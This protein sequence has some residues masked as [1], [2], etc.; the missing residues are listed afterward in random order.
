MKFKSLKARI[1]VVFISIILTIQIIGAVAIRFNIEKN[2]RASVNEQLVIGEK[3]FLS[4]LNQ[5]VEHLSQGARILA[6]D[7]GFR[8]AIGSSDSE[9][10]LSALQNQQERLGADLSIFFTSENDDLMISG[11]LSSEEIKKTIVKLIT[12]SKAN[13]DTKTFAIFQEQPYQLVAVPIKAPITIGWV[14]MGFKINDKLVK[15]LNQLS[16]LEV[17]FVSK[18]N[19]K[20]WSSTA[21]SLSLSEFSKLLTQVPAQLASHK[22][23]LETKLNDTVYGTRFV[24]IFN[25][26]NQQLYA[27]L[28]R[29][30]NEATSAYQSLQIS[31]MVLTIIGLLIIVSTILYL[32]KVITQPITDLVENAKKLEEGNYDIAITADSEDELGH[33]GRTF[34]RMTEAIAEREKSI[35]KLAYYDEL[36]SLPNRTSFLIALGKSLQTFAD[37]KQTLTVLVLNLDR[38]KQINNIL[39]YDAG[40]EILRILALRIK[41]S[42]KNTTDIIA[43]I[44][45]DQFAIMLLNTSIDAAED[46]ST[47]LLKFLET[48]IQIKNQTVDLSASVGLANYP[49]HANN[50]TE[51]ISRA[52]MAMHVAKSKNVG[53]VI[54]DKSFDLNSTANLSLESELRLAIAENQLELYVQPKIDIKTAKV[55]SL[56]ALIRWKHPIKGYIFPD[57]FI[58]FAEQTGFIHHI[59]LWVMNEAASLIAMWRDQAIQ[60]PIAINIS[61]RDLIDQNLTAQVLEIF[62][63][64]QIN[65]NS[66]EISFEITESSIMDDPVRALTTLDKLAS[67]QI[68]LSIDDFGTGYS[69]L[70]YLK[71]LPVSELKIDKS[72]VLKLEEDEDDRKIVQST[73]DLG[74]NLGLKVVAEGVENESVWHLL[75]QMGCDFGQGYYM[76]KPMHNN[77]F[78]KWLADWQTSEVYQSLIKEN[79]NKIVKP[80]VKDEVIKNRRSNNSPMRSQFQTIK[81]SKINHHK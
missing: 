35:A 19:N 63:L 57:Q 46:I 72:F 67:M 79:T 29:S 77:Q 81:T 58:P 3:V 11:D 7:Y 27:V 17:T 70:T 75:S 1:A 20:P 6:I 34:N 26:E 78:V 55:A 69:S 45:G 30:I 48:P 25:Q 12:Q 36:T 38:F 8:A 76:S 59:S 43:R 23:Q 51:L 16:N 62:N 9:T 15:K 74:H 18:S 73:I 14:V 2:A 42:L 44:G 37:D 60:I 24:T 47:K 33:L 54:F 13:A 40:D 80:N 5:N 21:T 52:E 22:A 71:K 32:S 66:P 65:L 61:T 4:L 56:E 31:L 49:E 50:V 39:G 28:Q 53:K 41:A 64:H 10:I 68:K